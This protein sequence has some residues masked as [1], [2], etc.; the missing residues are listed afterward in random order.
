LKA[1]LGDSV[2]SEESPPTSSTQPAGGVPLSRTGFKTEVTGVC[3]QLTKQAKRLK[4]GEGDSLQAWKNAIR[5]RGL[6]S[7]ATLQAGREVVR[8][9][10]Q[11]VAELA[12]R[13]Y[14]RL[15]TITPPKSLAADYSRY[16]KIGA[17]QI[18]VLRVEIR[19][20][21]IGDYGTIQRETPRSDS[22]KKSAKRL[23]RKLGISACESGN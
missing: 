22:L 15:S 19:A 13:A 4:R 1:K 10:Y 6:K 7:Q 8:D 21:E 17:T 16:L 18:D 14:A 5:S 9:I 11:P 23:A 3:A 12:N 20:L 2:K